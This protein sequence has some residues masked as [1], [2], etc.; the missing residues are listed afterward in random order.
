ME[1][2]FLEAIDE[3]KEQLNNVILMLETRN[4]STYFTRGTAKLDFLNLVCFTLNFV[5][6]SVQLELDD[7]FKKII[8]GE[9][10][11]SKQAY[12]QARQKIS[13]MV[14]VK[15]ADH[16]IRWYY[17]KKAY[18]TFMGY[19]LS[20][21]DGSTLELNNSKRLR[22]E[23]GYIRNQHI[24]VARAFTSA[25]YDIENDMILTSKITKYEANERTLAMELIEQLKEIG[26]KNDLILFDRGYPS[27]KLFKYLEGNEIKYLMR[28]KKRFSKAI[29]AAKKE[30]QVIEMAH[31][32]KT[33]KVRVLRFKLD[34]G[35]DEILVTNLFDETLGIKEFKALYFKRW[36]IETKFNELKSKLQIENFT[37]DT[38]IAVEQD[39]YASIYLA[40]MAALAKADANAKIEKRTAGKNLK[41]RYKV[42]TNVLIGKLRDTFIM[43]LLEEDKETRLEKYSELMKELQRNCIPIRPCRTFERNTHLKSNKFPLSK[44]RSL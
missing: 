8:E 18:K 10:T 37:G 5:K 13:P 32:G 12:S 31:A 22:D 40:N 1:N 9:L 7:F 30:D 20:A 3:T 17:N 39:F 44:K 21:I 27:A 38:P 19:R 42:N 16:I 2:S 41:H 14:F 36:G 15:L 4:K 43:I 26:L 35:T 25:I 29:S 23:Y 28:V 33:F 11:I 6:R 24:K 34:S